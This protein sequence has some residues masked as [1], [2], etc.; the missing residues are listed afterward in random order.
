LISLVKALTLTYTQIVL[1]NTVVKNIRTKVTEELK[2]C[3]PPLKI[4]SATRLNISIFEISAQ[5]I[6]NN[7]T[8]SIILVA[9]NT[10]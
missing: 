8:K 2:H 10:I 5:F 4:N 7:E 1:I 6:Q 9:A 3:I